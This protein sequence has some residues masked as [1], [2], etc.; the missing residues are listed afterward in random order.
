MR[1]HLQ[2]SEETAGGMAKPLKMR[3]MADAL[4]GYGSST[5]TSPITEIV[6]LT[7]NLSRQHPSVER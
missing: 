6:R 1:I 2:F 5:D 7:W 4:I 3:A